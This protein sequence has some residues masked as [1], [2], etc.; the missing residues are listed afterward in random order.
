MNDLR[1]GIL[2]TFKL[3]FDGILPVLMFIQF[4]VT[5]RIVGNSHGHMLT[6][7]IHDKPFMLFCFGHFVH[8]DQS[9]KGRRT[10]EKRINPYEYGPRND[11]IQPFHKMKIEND[12]RFS[13]LVV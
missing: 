9:H 6:L 5:N 7:Y 11:K 3:A 1:E 13:R 2:E 12:E 8:Y 4:G 10:I